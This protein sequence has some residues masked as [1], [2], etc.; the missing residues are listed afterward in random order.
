MEML[1][2]PVIHN[3][4]FSS[5]VPVTVEPLKSKFSSNYRPGGPPN[6]SRIKW[7]N[8]ATRLVEDSDRNKLIADRVD[9]ALDDGRV[10]LLLSQ[11]TEH[12]ALI[13][14]KMRHDA[15]ILAAS[16]DFKKTK[17][18]R[19]ELLDLFRKG[20]I[21][22]VLATQLA[23]EALD[24]PILNTIVLA[25]P[26]KF[27]D[28]LLQRV[29][30]ALRSYKGKHDALIIDVIDDRVANLRRNWWERRKYYR[31]WGFDIKT[32]N[33]AGIVVTKLKRRAKIQ[34]ATRQRKKA[35]AKSRAS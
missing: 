17:K 8:M 5:P 1:I 4:E 2:G 32:S 22:C 7:Q 11:R 25:F 26:T 33:P 18:Q 21:K 35:L 23:D 9:K 10:V 29:G 16:G 28:L 20:K 19:K 31:K 15:V 12:L 14:E 34:K 24:V 27:R 30:R 3:L 13:Q 6:L